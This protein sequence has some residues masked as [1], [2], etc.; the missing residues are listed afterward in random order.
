MR[1]SH[2]GALSGS[3]GRF[4][5]G[6]AA[7]AIPLFVFGAIAQDV[8]EGEPFAFDKA[9]LLGLRQPG[10]PSVPIGPRWLPEAARDVTS[11]GS[12]TVLGIV[13]F[14]VAGYLLLERR[15][16]AASW[17]LAAVGGGV[18]LENGLKLLFLRPRPEIVPAAVQVF[19]ASFPSG[20]ATMSAIAYLTLGVLLARTQETFGVRLYVMALAILLTFAV[21]V[22]RI[23]LGVHYPSDVL[24]GW[25]IGAAW[26][27]LCWAAAIWLQGRGRGEALRPH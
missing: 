15:R 18:L 23:Y 20:H 17:I 27:A 3:E 14:G 21:G 26:A 6:L 12:M 22:S 4:I 5:A 19:S 11:L 1:V 10:N 2:K 7:I 13:L 9:A 8:V 25:C 24:A 16:A